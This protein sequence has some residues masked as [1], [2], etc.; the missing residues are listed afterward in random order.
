VVTEAATDAPE[1]YCIRDPAARFRMDEDFFVTG[2]VIPEDSW[3]GRTQD[4]EET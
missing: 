3:Q 2:F 4:K 1:L